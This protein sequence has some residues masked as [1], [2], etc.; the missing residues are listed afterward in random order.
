MHV[1]SK[2]PV[3]DRIAAMMLANAALTF[4]SR[5]NMPQKTSGNAVA[6][7]ALISAATVTPSGVA[8]LV[9]LREQS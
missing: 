9:E 2:S 8:R 7:I 5:G 1:A 3:A 4:A 6:E